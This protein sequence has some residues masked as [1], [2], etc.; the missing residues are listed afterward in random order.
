MADEHPRTP[1]DPLEG[2]QETARS[3]RNGP[4]GRS[5]EEE[6]NVVLPDDMGFEEG[7]G[8]AKASDAG[9]DETVSGEPTVYDGQ[10]DGLGVCGPRDGGGVCYPPRATRR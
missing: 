8:T 4:K 10:D 9:K 1:E 2:E 3:S 5:V 6:L 7:G